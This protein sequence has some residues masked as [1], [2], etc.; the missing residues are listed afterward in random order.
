MAEITAHLRLPGDQEMLTARVF[1][2][3]LDLSS[4]TEFV[5]IPRHAHFGSEALRTTGIAVYVFPAQ[6]SQAFA[7]PEYEEMIAIADIVLCK[8]SP[9]PSAPSNNTIEADT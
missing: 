9:H 5:L 8:A 7:F 6:E 2:E 4:G 3:S 1:S